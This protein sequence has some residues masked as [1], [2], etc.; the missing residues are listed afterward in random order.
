MITITPVIRELPITIVVIPIGLVRKVIIL[1]GFSAL[2]VAISIV[3]SQVKDQLEY[4]SGA[5]SIANTLIKYF[6][7]E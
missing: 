4:A 5:E 1:K 6:P 7:F 3:I 2:F